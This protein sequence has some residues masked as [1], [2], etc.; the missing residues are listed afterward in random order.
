MLDIEEKILV[1]KAVDGDTKAF[2][3][4]VKM[5]NEKIF[6]FALSITGGNDATA[7]DIVQ[8]ALIKAFFNIRKF[9]RKSSFMSWLWRILRNEFLNYKK[10]VG[11]RDLLLSEDFKIDPESR[12][13]DNTEKLIEQEKHTRLLELISMLPM[14]DK[15]IITL[16][17]LNEMEYEEASEILGI[18][19]NSTRNRAFR[20]RARLAGLAEKHKNE[21]K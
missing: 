9:N 16:V 19:A 4:V 15:E 14:K 17:D 21:L 3:K 5:H 13:C 7:K 2:E 11:T 12:N 1:E 10:A 20:A 8:E 6:S 18:S